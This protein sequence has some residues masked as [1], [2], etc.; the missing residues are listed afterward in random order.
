VIAVNI[1]R[2]DSQAA[3]GR[4]D[5]KGLPTGSAELKLDRIVRASQVALAGL[6]ACQVGLRVSVKV[7]DR[8]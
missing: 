8:K 7:S 5:F 3:H 2:D 4:D 6:N 1:A